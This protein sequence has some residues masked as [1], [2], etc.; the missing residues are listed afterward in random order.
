MFWR[1][2]SLLILMQCSQAGSLTSISADDYDA[3]FHKYIPGAGGGKGIIFTITFQDSLPKYV[4]LKEFVVN[5]EVVEGKIVTYSP[6]AVV[7]GSKFYREPRRTIQNPEPEPASMPLFNAE[8]FQGTLTLTSEN[9]DY[10][11]SIEDF[12]QTSTQLNP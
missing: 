5:G 3:T 6:K 11:I 10:T 12:A 9:T 4:H 1:L 2:T 8:E 7:Q